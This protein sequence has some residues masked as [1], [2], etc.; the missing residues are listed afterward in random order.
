VFQKNGKLLYK[1]PTWSIFGPYQPQK[2]PLKSPYFVEYH[3]DALPKALPL[4]KVLC[5]YSQA[6]LHAAQC[7]PFPKIPTSGIPKLALA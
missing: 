4:L 7:L 5:P 1:I 3:H 6:R 2:N